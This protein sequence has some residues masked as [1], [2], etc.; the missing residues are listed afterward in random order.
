MIKNPLC[1]YACRHKSRQHGVHDDAEP[2]E[3]LVA[4][5][6][7]PYHGTRARAQLWLQSRLYSEA[8]ILISEWRQNLDLRCVLLSDPSTFG[9]LGVPTKTRLEIQNKEV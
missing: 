1:V 3:H 2:E 6:D 8:H 5:A 7:S 9:A 4:L